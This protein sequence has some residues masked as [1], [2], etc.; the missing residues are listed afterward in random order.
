MHLLSFKQYLHSEY[1]SW[2][3]FEITLWCVSNVFTDLLV[4]FRIL[5]LASSSLL[6]IEWENFIFLWLSYSFVT[7]LYL[8]LAWRCILLLY[9]LNFNPGFIL[10]LS[11]QIVDSLIW[12]GIRDIINDFR[13][14]KLKLRP[15]TYLS[16]SHG[17]PSDVPTGYIWSPHLVPKP[18]GLSF[19]YHPLLYHNL[20]SACVDGTSRPLGDFSILSYLL[21][22]GDR[23]SDDHPKPLINSWQVFI[24]QNKCIDPM[25]QSLLCGPL[26]WANSGPCTRADG[27][28]PSVWAE[29]GCYIYI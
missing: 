16:G 14:K 3:S 27:N 17:S 20:S 10:Q 1:E 23:G 7:L 22:Y 5:F 4:N 25:V 26:R 19:K 9:S 2:G 28:L 15:V 18:K 21:V 6:H 11:Y 12:L 13:K 8:R 29:R 24:V